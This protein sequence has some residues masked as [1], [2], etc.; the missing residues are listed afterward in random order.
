MDYK[1]KFKRTNDLLIQEETN[2]TALLHPDGN[3]GYINEVGSFL[4]RHCE[5]KNIEQLYELLLTEC[6]DLAEI[7]AKDIKKDIEG[8]MKDLCEYGY[9]SVDEGGQDIV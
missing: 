5:G 3:L 1:N 8:F 9:V 2:E 4:W 7:P 6:K